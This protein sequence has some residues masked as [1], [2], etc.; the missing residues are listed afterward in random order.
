MYVQ[1]VLNLFAINFSALIHKA[2]LAYPVRAS[3]DLERPMSL[4]VKGLQVWNYIFDY[5][6]NS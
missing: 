1:S 4:C 6:K 3:H 2:K 5:L